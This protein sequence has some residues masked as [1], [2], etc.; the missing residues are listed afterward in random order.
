MQ[1]PN[2]FGGYPTIAEIEL[3]DL[4]GPNVIQSEQS[5]PMDSPS[6]SA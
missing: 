6:A 5:A 3:L 2:V 4:V 1:G